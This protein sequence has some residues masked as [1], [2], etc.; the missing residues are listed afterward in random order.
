MNKEWKDYDYKAVNLPTSLLKQVDKHIKSDP[1]F[2]STYRSRAEFVRS[3]IISKIKDDNIIL[4]H[5]EKT[6]ELGK[7]VNIKEFEKEFDRLIQK[8][9]KIK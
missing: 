4:K 8:L 5:K 2:K 3:A 1:F 6:E 9:K 7:Y